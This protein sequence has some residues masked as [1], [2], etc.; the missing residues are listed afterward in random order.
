MLIDSPRLSQSDREHWDRAETCDALRASLGLLGRKADRARQVIRDFA[1][2]GACIASVSWGKDSTVLAHLVATA[3]VDVP[4]VWW[5]TRDFETPESDQVRDAFLAAHPVRYEQRETVFRFPKRGEPGFIDR[6]QAKFAAGKRSSFANPM[7]ERYITGVRGQE[8]KTR[9][10]AMGRHGE[11]SARS[12]RPIGNWTADDV[13]AYLHQH[14]LPVHPAYAMT[15]GGRLA[16]DTIRV[17]ALCCAPPITGGS[18]DM[19]LSMLTQQQTW[20]DHY[21]SDVI[22]SA[23]QA[24]AHMWEGK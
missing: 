1:A 23:Y 9:R 8:S 17:H 19:W 21:Y 13:F 4:L 12:C 2:A 24:R 20:E 5:R 15:M 6:E 10:M 18:W 11:A 16:R 22:R 7:R 14:Q 3:G